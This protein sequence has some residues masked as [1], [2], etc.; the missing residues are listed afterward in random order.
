MIT[1]IKFQDNHL[2][3]SHC[4]SHDHIQALVAS[5]AANLNSVLTQE[6]RTSLTPIKGTLSLLKHRQI[7]SLSK[8]GQDL[9]TIALNNTQRLIRL[10]AAIEGESV[11]PATIL[12]AEEIEQ[13]QL[14]NELHL[15]WEHQ[16]FQLAYQPII[17]LESNSINGFEVLLRWQHPTKGFI[18]PADFIPLVEQTGLIHKLGLW[19]LEQA[20]RQLFLWQQQFPAYASVAISVN[21][22]PLQ[23]LQPEL[24]EQVRKIVKDT[25]IAFSSLKFEITETALIQNYEIA[26][27]ILQ[28]IKAM[29]I[30]IHID[31]FGTG[32][33]SLSRLQDLPIDALKIDRSFVMRKKWEIIRTIMLLASRLGLDVIAEGVETEEDLASLKRLKCKQVQGYFFSKPLDSEGVE[34]LITGSGK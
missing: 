8:E 13:L 1:M 20:C 17:C 19:V 31:D 32:Y 2:L 26:S 14:E 6:I 34:K 5:E 27:R 22:S 16:E 12:S 18:T 9:L 7:S 10:I 21:L 11:L 24:V 4:D 28:E 25:G 33:S 30:E 3:Q 15:A 23:L 29:G